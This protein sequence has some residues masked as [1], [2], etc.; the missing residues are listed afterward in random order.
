MDDLTGKVC[1]HV[2]Q[3]VL[4]LKAKL[5]RPNER[6][7]KVANSNQQPTGILL[8]TFCALVLGGVDGVKVTLLVD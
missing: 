5:I 1:H 3:E 4:L 7:A 2:V 8:D 6:T